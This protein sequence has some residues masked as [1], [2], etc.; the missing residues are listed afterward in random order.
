LFQSTLS[1]DPV[2]SLDDLLTRG[3][4]DIE[5]SKSIQNCLMGH[6]ACSKKVEGPVGSWGRPVTQNPCNSCAPDRRELKCE[7]SFAFLS[8][9]Y[10]NR[11]KITH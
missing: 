11:L 2:N 8:H 1:V 5:I 4:V 6:T 7:G 10:V 3:I 9:F